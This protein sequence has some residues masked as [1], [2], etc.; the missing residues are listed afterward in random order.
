MHVYLRYYDG[1]WAT[2]RFEASWASTDAFC[3]KP[4]RF[5]MVDIDVAAEK[6]EE[7]LARIEAHQ[8]GGLGQ[9]SLHGLYHAPDRR[10]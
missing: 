5:L 10:R 1:A 3:N 8:L 2:T 7:K 6:E 9:D 4:V